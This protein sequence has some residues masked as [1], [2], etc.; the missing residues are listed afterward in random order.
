MK[1]ILLSILALFFPWFVILIDGQFIAAL[2]C[3]ALQL[4]FVGWIPASIWAW[5]V[6]KRMSISTEEPAETPVEPIIND[7]T[8]IETTSSESELVIE[9]KS[10]KKVS[11]NDPPKTP[12]SS[13]KAT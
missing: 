6:A 4:S 11:V 10:P 9:K 2:A 1:R 5:K 13:R 12:S 3:L 7:E 8:P